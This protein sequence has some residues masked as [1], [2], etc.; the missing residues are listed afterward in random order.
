MA[1]G[2]EKRTTL[3]NADMEQTEVRDSWGNTQKEGVQE[4]CTE[5]GL[6]EKEGRRRGK[7]SKQLPP[8][9]WGALGLKEGLPWDQHKHT[10]A[11][12]GSSAAGL[13]SV[14]FPK[15]RFKWRVL[16][17]TTQPDPGVDTEEGGMEGQNKLSWGLS[18]FDLGQA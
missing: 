8:G 11:L 17:A 9:R 13:L 18:E 2:V 12:E 6:M 3:K 1:V 15:R 14:I 7:L 4:L 10:D 5:Q 16:T